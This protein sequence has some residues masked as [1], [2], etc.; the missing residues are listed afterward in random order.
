MKHL[1]DADWHA[2]FLLGAAEPIVR[3]AEVVGWSLTGIAKS[4]CEGTEPV[5]DSVP[6]Q[7][8]PPNERRPPLQTRSDD[9]P[10]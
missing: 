1:T 6:E 2:L 3:D 8:L 7:L 5:D 4:I 10:S 9:K